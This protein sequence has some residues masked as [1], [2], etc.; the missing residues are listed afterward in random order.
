MEL[1]HGLI[2]LQ[3]FLCCICLL[4]TFCPTLGTTVIRLLGKVLSTLL[5]WPLA[6]LRN[7]IPT[8]P[9]P[10][11]W[12]SLWSIV[13]LAAVQIIFVAYQLVFVLHYNARKSQKMSEVGCG[14][15][16]LLVTNTPSIVTSLLLYKIPFR[17][18]RWKCEEKLF[19]GVVLFTATAG[20]HTLIVKFEDRL[21]PAPEAFLWIITLSIQGGV[22]GLVDILLMEL[23]SSICTNLAAQISLKLVVF[24]L[25][26]G[27]TFVIELLGGDQFYRS[28]S[29]ILGCSALVSCIVYHTFKPT[30]ITPSKELLTKSYYTDL[31]K[32]IPWPETN[33]HFVMFKNKRTPISLGFCFIGVYGPLSMVVFQTHLNLPRLIGI[34]KEH[35]EDET[36]PSS[37]YYLT[38]VLASSTAFLI[39]KKAFRTDGSVFR[40]LAFIWFSL[41]GISSTL[42][43]VLVNKSYHP[44]LGFTFVLFCY[45]V[46]EENVKLILTEI[47]SRETDTSNVVITSYIDLV[48]SVVHLAFALTGIVLLTSVENLGIV[49]QSISAMLVK[50]TF[51]VFAVGVIATFLQHDMKQY[52]RLDPYEPLSCLGLSCSTI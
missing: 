28:I 19:W 30:L 52:W 13:C 9:R 21:W 26:A 50:G 20:I 31:V 1:Y 41:Y 23:T 18:L 17:A 47:L 34:I 44:I 16:I 38:I 12:G 10:K 33:H 3:I 6:V 29:I 37:L 24:Y 25:A 27:L 14:V 43:M 45:N 8:I 51:P 32:S 22:Q 15:V 49:V 35:L 39:S 5:S 46:A 2:A 40:S 4:A 48:V 7:K 36:L 42:Q 11:D